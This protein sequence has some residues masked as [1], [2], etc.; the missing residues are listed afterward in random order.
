MGLSR[1]EVRGV[2]EVTAKNL[3]KEDS[4][5]LASPAYTANGK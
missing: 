1:F 5:D 2:K 3:I 4:K